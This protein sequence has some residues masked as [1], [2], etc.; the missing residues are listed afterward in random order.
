MNKLQTAFKMMDD[1]LF[2]QIEKAKDSDAALQFNQ[3]LSKFNPEVQKI[4]NVGLNL[5]LFFLPLLFLIFFIL[6]NFSIQGE[7]STKKEILGL[8]NTYTQKKI[9]VDTHSR[10]VISPRYFAKQSDLQNQL[11]QA[12]SSSGFD[13]TKVT[14]SGFNQ[15]SSIKPLLKTEA[16]LR[17]KNIT[18][19]NLTGLLTSLLRD[20]KVKIVGINIKLEKDDSTLTGSL[21]INHYAK[22]K[23]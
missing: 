6:G 22:M 16:K 20:F 12:Y 2:T 8:I 10:S 15:D 11:Q 13:Q 7:I 1:A 3:F 17:F 21:D 19:S 18:L 9:E 23:K 4:I 14:L 5:S